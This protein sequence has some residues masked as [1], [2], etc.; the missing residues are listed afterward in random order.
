MQNLAGA[1]SMTVLDT[2]CDWADRTWFS[3]LQVDSLNVY[4]AT[5]EIARNK[6]CSNCRDAVSDAKI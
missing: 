2:G 3:K 5:A 4:I 1:A 6:L